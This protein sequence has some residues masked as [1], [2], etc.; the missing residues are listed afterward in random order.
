MKKLYVLT[1]YVEIYDAKAFTHEDW[2]AARRVANRESHG[3]RNW[4]LQMDCLAH[5][6]WHEETD[7]NYVGTTITGYESFMEAMGPCGSDFIK[8]S[9]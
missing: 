1:D 9:D 4:L 3:K 6:P 8:E 5:L 2:I 7:G